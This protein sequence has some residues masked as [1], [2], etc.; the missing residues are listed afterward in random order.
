MMAH[1]LELQSVSRS[2]AMCEGILGRSVPVRAVDDVSLSVER[3]MTL[4]LVG[5]SGSGK[6]TTGRIALGLEAP[7]GGKV[8]FQG[9]V[10]PQADT[11]PWRQMR[12]RMQMIYQDPLAALDRRLPIIDQIREPLDVHRMGAEAERAEKAM[13]VLNAVGIRP[14]L[15]Q[16]YPHELSGGQRQRAILARAL[17]TEPDLLVCDEP[18]SALDVSIQ[19]QV[20]NLLLDLQRDLGLSMLFISHDLK[21]VRHVSHRTAVMY[22]GRIVEIGETERLLSAPVHPYTEALVSAAPVPG[23]RSRPRVLLRGEPPNPAAR[24]SGC[25]FHPRCPFARTE[26]KIESP[27]LESMPDGR[28]VACHIAHERIRPPE[29]AS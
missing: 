22:L 20:V 7:D 26:C 18:V 14:D 19:A 8:T 2:Y 28:L 10:L 24:P 1:I 21:V 23:K 25:A 27:A 6:S 12:A 3:G 17:V 5:E 4:G 16:R 29:A 13:A 11:V 9:K 15:A